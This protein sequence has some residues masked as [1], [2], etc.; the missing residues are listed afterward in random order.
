MII[1]KMTKGEIFIYFS[2]EVFDLKG[3]SRISEVD[4]CQFF[5][6]CLF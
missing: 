6:K 4:L 3:Y 2:K 1:L 5:K